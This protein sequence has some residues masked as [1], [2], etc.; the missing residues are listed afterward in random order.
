M[1]ANKIVLTAAQARELDRRYCAETGLPSIVLM[2]RA[3]NALFREVEKRYPHYKLVFLLGGGNNAGDGWNLALIAGAKGYDLELLDF[4]AERELPSDAAKMREACRRSGFTIHSA[5]SAKARLAELASSPR[6]SLIIDA[7]Y[8]SGFNLRRRS[9]LLEQVKT[10]LEKLQS[11]GAKVL[12]VDCPSGLDSESGGASEFTIKADITVTFGA[13]KY[14]LVSNAGRRFAGDIVVDP[15]GFSAQLLESVHAGDRGLEIYYDTVD[16]LRSF[17]PTAAENAHK[18][19]FAK[20]CITAASSSYPG[21]GLLAAKAALI[22]GVAYLHVNVESKLAIEVLAKNPEIVVMPEFKED[23]ADLAH[24]PVHLVG[25][26]LGN[27]LTESE[28]AKF[29]EGASQLVLD[30]DA[31]NLIAKSDG[32]LLKLLEKRDTPAILTPQPRE[33]GRLFPNLKMTD[34]VGRAVEAARQSHQII[35]AKD[36]RTVVALPNGRAYFNS[37]GNRLL[38]KAGSGDCLAGLITGLLARGLAPDKAARMGVLIHGRSADL[39]YRDLQTDYADLSSFFFRY[40][41]EVLRLS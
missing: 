21:A 40:L 34:Q 41:R 12:A 15:I 24:L 25:P 20:T 30:A 5:D 2:E 28:L 3:A 37:S 16:Q 1:S 23:F 29:I 18:G 26:G 14:A 32:R 35:V 19:S 36:A 27:R 6:Q 31:L 11:G 39:A 38:A 13:L 17:L 7:L 10:P 4:T 33:F 22:A 8:G 9:K